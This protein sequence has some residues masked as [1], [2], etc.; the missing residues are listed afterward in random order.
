MGFKFWII[1]AIKVFV[2]VVILLFI[3]EQLKGHSLED[4]IL[5]SI[6]WSFLSTSV[7]IGSRVY[8]SRK[9][10][11]CELCNDTPDQTSKNT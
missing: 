1:R 7:F 3:V 8:Q 4:S 5:F 9:G 2:S 11:V 6:L 10:I